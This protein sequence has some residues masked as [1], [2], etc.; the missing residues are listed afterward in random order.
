[1]CIKINKLNGR[2]NGSYENFAI[3]SRF[4]FRFNSTKKLFFVTHKQ[5]NKKK[6]LCQRTLLMHALFMLLVRPRFSIA[7]LTLD[8][9][10][11][12]GLYLLRLSSGS[13]SNTSLESLLC[14]IHVTWKKQRSS[15]S[16]IICIIFFFTFIVSMIVS[17]RS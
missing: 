3:V 9:H 2:L 11:F 5:T 13:H 16:S 14:L 15:F 7:T 17:L 10:V 8:I 1:M 4:F 12:L 6:R